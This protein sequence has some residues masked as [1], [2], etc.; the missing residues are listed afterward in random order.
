MRRIFKLCIPFICL[1]TTALQAQQ[2]PDGVWQ[3]E[4][5]T[6][7][8]GATKSNRLSVYKT[9]EIDQAAQQTLLAKTPREGSS[10]A[11]IGKTI[12]LP[13]PD[14][15]FARF[16]ILETQVMAP[17][18]AAN[19]PEI[20]TYTGWG[21]DD[22]AASLRID[23]SPNGFHAQVLSPD[24]A[25]YIDPET[26]GDTTRAIS[27]FKRDYQ[28]SDNDFSCLVDG[29]DIYRSKTI[30]PSTAA[31]SGATLRT[32]RLACATTGEYTAYHGGTVNS[33]LAAVVTAIN[34]VTG[35][36]EVELSIR[37]QLVA[38]NNLLI[39]T[40]AG[41][42]PYTNN[43]D[44]ALLDENQSNIDSVIGDAN[45][46]IGHVFSTDG[47]G[48]ANLASVGIS[49]Q[50][51]EGETG[52]S[53]PT[54]DPFYIDYVAHEIG[55]QFGANHT[56]NGDSG[57]CSGNRNASTAYEP[58]SGSTIMS[59]AGICGNDDFQNNSDPQFHSISLDEILS[60]VDGTISAVG[61]RTATGNSVPSINAGDDYTIPAQ[62][63]FTLTASASDSDGNGSLTYSWEQ[64]DLGPQ[65]DLNAGDNGFSPL[66]RVWT[67]TSDPT[68][69]FPR[70]SDMVNNTVPSGETMPTTTRTMNFRATVRDNASNGGGVDTDDMIINVVNTG[71]PFLVTSPNTAVNWPA[72]SAQ[73][74][75]WNV[76]G[77][78]GNGINASN[79]SI[80]LS[81]DGGLT[82]PIT[83]L[84]STPNDGSQQITL[85]SNQT[86]Q[87]RIR[88]M[89]ESNIFFDISDQNFTISAPQ[90]GF[91]VTS[92]P[93]N[94]SVCAPA[95]AIFTINVPSTGTFTA[96]V[97]LSANG[98]PAGTSAS[99]STN[100][101]TPDNSTTLTISVTGSAASGT[102]PI[103]IE[104]NGGSQQS[105]A[106]IAL[107]ISN[108]VPNSVNLISPS[109]GASEG[110]TP[111]FEWS[112]VAATN[113]RLEVDDDPAFGSPESSILT[114]LTTAT[115][116]SPLTA[117]TP[118]YWRVTSINHCG[119]TTSE[120]RYFTT[121][122]DGALPEI[123]SSPNV[124]IPDDDSNGVTDTLITSETGT[125]TD[126]DLRLNIT[127]TWIGDLTVVLTH[128]DTG[129]SVMVVDWPGYPEDSGGSSENNIIVI[130]DDEAALTVEDNSPYTT[131]AHYSPNNPLSAFDGESLTGT[132]TLHV[133]DDLGGDTGTLV[134]WCLQP[135][136]SGLATVF[137]RLSAGNVA[138]FEDAGII[139]IPYSLDSASSAST[140]FD[141]STQNDS[142]IAGSDYVAE[143]D[144]ANITASTTSGS[145]TITLS[146]DSIFEEDERFYLILD[147]PQGMIIPDNLVEITLSDRNAD[148]IDWLSNN[149]LNLADLDVDG[150]N[151][152]INTLLEFSFNL[153]P[154]TNSIVYY[155][156][157]ASVGVNGPTGLPLIELSNEGNNSRL[158]IT[159]P[160]RKTVPG[161]KL[162]YANWF[163]N[164]LSGWIENTNESVESI[165]SDW[166]KVSVSDSFT[167]Q[168]APEQ[169]RF[170]KVTIDND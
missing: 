141:Y 63:P 34:R 98:L 146:A 83:I 57:S 80:D 10:R 133:N 143:S 16:A 129:T 132:W 167:I 168:T 86:S 118:Y 23:T 52:L 35:V 149:G 50:K 1:L 61:T 145:L 154:N 92:T 158:Q 152:G 19:Y 106:F 51:A 124:A 109:Q 81:T 25:V 147:N 49:G 117:N 72:Y 157:L 131:N 7:A 47:G 135:T 102:Y 122:T 165:D 77:T 68:R 60:H 26:L 59:Y 108:G 12:Y 100:P 96:P 84:A 45:Y 111:S 155:D 76:A 78:T 53:N 65:L 134:S 79:V 28:K 89:G 5:T 85:P 166:E 29:D 107:E 128:V 99:F 119:E 44:S 162:D 121:Q 24:G 148:V 75:T 93:E 160:R 116:S 3:F 38:N 95:D 2:S 139:N 64:R 97:T 110:S 161:M 114:D 66:F 169:K 33:G 112:A 136:V 70:V 170:G 90:D 40:N 104:G 41:T 126:L 55:H 37:L 137:P 87:A 120:Y 156:P 151:D 103:E 125:I 42:D 54:G 9:L 164:S 115:I 11:S 142:A 163:S 43:N 22:P 14:G 74:I 138:E 17:E 58:G 6:A 20:K 18:L 32:Y 36:Y 67:P 27:Y 4:T 105:S 82:Y 62:T 31:R 150:D 13:M 71:A 144:T 140:S 69:T 46:D 39:Y 159:Y 88:V 56:F 15:S 30:S 8:K 113:Y 123:C 48:L 127:H 94:D 73:T 91:L 153:N 101:V 130:L 21:I